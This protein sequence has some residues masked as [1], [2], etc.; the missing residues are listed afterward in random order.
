[1]QPAQL[2]YGSPANPTGHSRK[3]VHVVGDAA[4]GAAQSEGGADDERQAA[5]L[6][7][8]LRRVGGTQA[9]GAV[10]ALPA[11]RT[12]IST[13][14][15]SHAESVHRRHTCAPAAHLHALLHGGGN[16]GHSHVQAQLVH[17]LQAGQGEWA[18]TGRSELCVDP[19]AQTAFPCALQA[20]IK[21][22]AATPWPK[23][24]P[25]RPTC[26]KRSRSS[27]LLMDASLAPISST[28]Y[29]SRMPRCVEGIGGGQMWAGVVRRS[30]QAVE[31]TSRAGGA[32]RRVLPGQGIQVTSSAC[33]TT[34]HMPA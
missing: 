2:P 15:G 17:G 9:G 18:T 32:T 3:L 22:A 34:A 28:P 6:L 23:P 12:A 19:Q 8:S 10:S 11:A 29:F 7:S 16:A 4:A 25:A 26:A 27:A 33:S 30:L 20:T 21:P 1:M 13:Y 5:N 14:Y 31:E 24:P